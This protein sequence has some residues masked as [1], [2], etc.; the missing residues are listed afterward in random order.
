MGFFEP[1]AVPAPQFEQGRPRLPWEE[2]LG[3]SVF[4]DVELAKG[5]DGALLLRNLVVFPA[6]MTL[7]VVAMF[8][9]PL[10]H[11][12]GTSGNNSPTFSDGRGVR[13]IGTGFVSFGLRFSDGST[14]RNLDERGNKGRLG[15]RVGGGGGFVGSQEFWAPVPPQGDFDVWVAWPAAGIPET[16]TVLDGTRVRETANALKRLWI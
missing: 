10:V 5:L 16:R 3:Q 15:T 12:P 1:V 13:E 11:G 4:T 8:R 14:Y 6:V 9:Q 7:S 2:G